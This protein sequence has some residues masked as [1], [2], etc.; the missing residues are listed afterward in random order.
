MD[1]VGQAWIHL[2][3]PDADTQSAP[4]TMVTKTWTLPSSSPQPRV[5]SLNEKV[6]LENSLLPQRSFSPTIVSLGW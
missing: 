4:E 5:G 3:I 1:I 2:F 6:L